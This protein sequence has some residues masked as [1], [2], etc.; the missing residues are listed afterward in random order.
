VLEAHQV[1]VVLM[2]ETGVLE[3]PSLNFNFK[4]TCFEQH[5]SDFLVFL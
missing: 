2:L 5:F 1:G 4:T 3:V